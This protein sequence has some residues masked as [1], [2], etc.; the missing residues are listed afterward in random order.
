MP[1]ILCDPRE[2]DLRVN[3]FCVIEGD[4]GSERSGYLSSFLFRCERQIQHL[5]APAILRRAAPREVR[6]WHYLK[7][8]ENEALAVCREKAKHQNLDMKITDLRFEDSQRKVVFHFTADKRV[9]FRE[10][11]KD[12]AAH[13]HARI[14]LW[15]IGVRDEARTLGGWGTCGCSLCCATWLK[16][17]APVSIRFAKTQDLQ[18]SPAKLSGACGRLRCCLAFEQEQYAELAQGV[19]P[20]GSVVRSAEHGD[21]KVVDRNLLTQ[22]LNVANAEGRVTVIPA[23]GLTRME[24]TDGQEGKKASVWRMRD[25]QV[26]SFGPVAR[27]R[28]DETPLEGE[29]REQSPESWVPAF[30]EEP[31]AGGDEAVGPRPEGDSFPEEETGDRAG[32]QS[33]GVA[34]S[35]REEE[36]KPGKARRRKR[37]RR[38]RTK[39][40]AASRPEAT[41]KRSEP[42]APAPGKATPLASS[43]PNT[44]AT[45][46]RHIRFGRNRT[47]RGRDS[48]RE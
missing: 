5:E 16:E 39:L 46:R 23:C 32:A 42:G 3:D 40:E 10:L 30:V 28:L 44:G 33:V 36:D 31:M 2:L 26:L 7:R 6:A 12:L 34:P 21:L 27:S 43:E 38:Q 19:P 1:P 48:S 25:D 29:A 15:Q 11:V 20:I 18:F 22:T 41:L 37:R 24:P 13:F 14:E 8:R 17:F 47:G 4:N 35:D 45:T 9:D